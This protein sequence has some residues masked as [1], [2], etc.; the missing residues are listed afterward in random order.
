M[1]RTKSGWGASRKN[2]AAQLIVER[3]TGQPQDMTYVN[4][5]M[6]WGTQQEPAAR[7]MYEFET[8]C[9]VEQVGMVIHGSINNALASPDGLVGS[10]GLIEIKCPN[11][12]TH[13]ET[14]LGEQIPGKYVLQMQWQLQC[15]GRD[16]CDFVSFD[17]R[18]PPEMSLWIK[19]YHSDEGLGETLEAEVHAF[20]G[21][22]EKTVE[23][24]RS[25]FPAP[26]V[27]AA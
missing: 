23:Q 27:L 21:E 16:W 20:L 10:D 8:D 26:E 25:K 3:L 5:A 4:D 6:L 1:A 7:L 2:Y 15:T 11:T 24:L 18:V 14:L 22:I 9:T 13:I 19:R 12:A 17:P